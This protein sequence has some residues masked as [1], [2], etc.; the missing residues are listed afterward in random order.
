MESF[1]EFLFL[2][3]IEFFC[4]VLFDSSFGFIFFGVLW[5]RRVRWSWGLG[6]C[7]FV[8][9]FGG[10]YGV[11]RACRSRIVR[12]VSG[13]RSGRGV[14]RGVGFCFDGVRFSIC[15]VASFEFEGTRSKER[16]RRILGFRFWKYLG[17][18]FLLRFLFFGCLF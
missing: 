3:S 15:V 7:R 9:A 18:I 5:I 2:K 4:F 13:I 10:I 8:F 17:N 12:L 14:W 11:V 6:F 16:V 1:L